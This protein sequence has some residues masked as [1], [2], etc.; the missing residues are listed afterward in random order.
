MPKTQGPHGPT[1]MPTPPTSAGSGSSANVSNYAE[2]D[3]RPLLRSLELVANLPG[4]NAET[5]SF[6]RNLKA[7][8]I[9]A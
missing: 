1:S 8:D 3:L 7:G 6:I 4:S 2:D 9:H 5:R